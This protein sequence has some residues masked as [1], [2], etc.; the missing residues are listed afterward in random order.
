MCG[1]A[2]AVWS[3][4]EAAVERATLQ[5]MTESL[6]HRG[7]DDQGIAY[8]AW[9]PSLPN[10]QGHGWG[11]GFRRLSI[12]DL[13]TGH[14]PMSNEDDSIHIVFNGEI[15]NYH[16]LRRRL[17]GSG[18]RFKTESDTETIVHLYEDLDTDCFAHL[19]GM[20]AIAI[21]DGRKQRLILARDRMGEKPLF[22]CEQS[23]RI[24]FASELK[25]L[26]L[27]PGFRPP[28]DPGAIDLFLTYQY[29]PHPFS[30][31]QGV[32]KLEPGHFL[33][34]EGNH[35]QTRPFW[36]VDWSAEEPMS[37]RDAQ[38]SVKSLL[39]DAVRL[40]L[41]SDVPL[42]AFLSGGIDS[43]LI[44]ALAQKHLPHPIQTFSIGFPVKDYDETRFARL[45]ANHI[46]SKHREFEVS[47]DA[48]SILDQ[49]AYHYDEPFG[50]SSAIPT[51]YLSKLTRNEVT[52]ALSGDGGDELFAGYDRYRAVWLSQRLQSVLPLNKLLPVRLIQRLPSSDRQ[53]SLLRRVKRFVE[54]LDQPIAKRYLNWIQI[55]SEASRI[56]LY[57][58]DFIEQLPNRDPVDFLVTAWNRALHRDIITRASLADMQTYIPCDLMTKVDIASMAHSL[59]VRQ[60]FLDFRLVELSIRMPSQ[61]KFHRQTGKRILRETFA[62]LL[63]SSIWR[64]PKMGFGVP[65]AEWFKGP[66][67]ATTE[68]L[69]L[70]TAAR[71]HQ[72][73]RR[74]AIEN[75]MQEHLANRSNHAY[76]LWNLVMLE[77][78]LRQWTN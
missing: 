77:Q 63:P 51:W 19:N 60:P 23:H 42:G 64:R 12:I 32:R 62:N 31:Y 47:P 34:F 29:V 36:N 67:R 72:F 24:S 54:A 75:L 49:L 73:F 37:Y 53:R 33:V 38:D 1:I 61:W 59:E 15:Y 5:R 45:V 9:S 16:E 25:A 21:W 10:Q 8:H 52:V 56:S 69:L 22:Y 20:F 76:R 39:D 50:D 43:S 58:E 6:S 11:L 78:W 3:C 46:G 48:V 44:V 26:M 28:I 74:E 27:L 13:A 2:G 70:D 17:E 4:P 41:R 35:A 57:R 55:F 65:L 14:Q 68:S 40:R 7:P 71:C 66:L 30:I 18:H